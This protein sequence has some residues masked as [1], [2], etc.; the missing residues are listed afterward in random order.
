MQC[1]GFFFK[2]NCSGHDVK[3]IKELVEWNKKC[4]QTNMNKL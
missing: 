2:K 3:T 1:Q 4:R